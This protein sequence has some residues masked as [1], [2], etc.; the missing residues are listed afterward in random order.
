MVGSPGEINEIPKPEGKPRVTT[1]SCLKCGAPM[2]VR[3]PGHSM[4]AVC[5][6]CHSIIDTSD[7]EFRILSTYYKQM[8]AEPRIELGTRGELKGTTW[9]VIGFVVR[10]DVA[11]G[12]KW[13]EY[14]LF[15][16]YYGYRWL[17]CNNGHW[18]LVTM[19]KHR[20]DRVQLAAHFE[21]ER[22]KTFYRGRAKVV[23][24]Y[25]EFYWKVVLGEQV[26]MTDYV[27]PPKMLSVEEDRKQVVWSVSDYLEPREVAA[28]FGLDPAIFPRPIGVAPNQPAHE[29]AT[30][31]KVKPMWLL[32]LIVLTGLQVFHFTLAKNLIEYRAPFE[33][34]S[35]VDGNFAEKPKQPEITTPEFVLDKANSNLQI[36]I[37]TEVDNSW[38]YIYGELVNSDTEES[39][40]FERTVEY[41][42]GYEGGEYW[43]EGSRSTSVFMPQVPGGKYYMNLDIDNGGNTT[44][45]PKTFSVTVRRDVPT[46]NNYLWCLVLLSLY[47][48]YA[49]LASRTVEVNR[50]S[51]SDFS[52]YTSSSD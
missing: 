42:H 7:E 13:E 8:K 14:L 12:F 20:P 5:D 3:Y 35:K 37:D 28:A 45:G 15:N 38:F 43:S 9:E 44:V 41:Y 39:F 40:S 1:F 34:T 26:E 25:G 18:S 47:P 52:P 32:F 33:Y 49:W 10:E 17:M 16:P 21:N 29:S 6:S 46:Y 30:W 31:R 36:N 11:S 2:T 4:S 51:D 22:Y 23:F 48:I 50:W 27:T 19:I 24:V